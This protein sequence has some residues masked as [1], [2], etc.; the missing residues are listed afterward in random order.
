MELY[1]LKFKPIL[2]EK[3]WGGN[4]MATSLNKK[5]KGTQLGESWEISDVQGNISQ[6]ENGKY[7]GKNLQELIQQY[8]LELLGDSQAKEFP[9]L[10]KFL[11]ANTPLSIQVHP[12]EEQAQKRENSHGK[13]EMWYVVEATPDAEIYLGWK[14]QYPQPELEKAYRQG[15]IKEYLNVIKPKKG[16]FYYVPAGSV[17][18]LGKGLV[19]AEIQQTSDITYRIYD[20][21][22]TDR[23]LHIDQAIAVT[24]YSY[25]SSF[26]KEYNTTPNALHKVVQSPFFTTQYLHITQE[27]EL[28][29]AKGFRILMCVEGSG[30]I[31]HN[32]KTTPINLGETVLIPAAMG[33]YS[34]S[35]TNLKLLLTHV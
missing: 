29:K 24:N 25:Q 16:E 20:W 11:D 27:T 23:E 22:R 12:N 21:G 10:I 3:V 26:K 7:K 19:I 5:Y 9:L 15:C 18:A 35:S 1:P 6:I 17:H 32:G 8:P 33:D 30:E 2:K 4:Q 28:Q 34:L 14:K 13:T 31:K